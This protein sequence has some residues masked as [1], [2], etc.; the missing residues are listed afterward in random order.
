MNTTTKTLAA[1][2][3]LALLPASAYAAPVSIAIGEAGFE[4]APTRGAVT[5]APWKR[6]SNGS[7]TV[8]VES[9]ASLG[10]QVDPVPGGGN[11]LHYNN[12]S[13][14][15][16]YQVLA[17]TLEANTT[18]VLAI[19]AVDRSNLN[20]QSS[21][22]RFGTVSGVDD[23]TSG[24]L[25]ANDFFGE[26][27]LTPTAVVNTTPLNAPVPSTSDGTTNP[28]DGW[29][30]WSYTFTTGDSPAGLDDALRIEIIGTG[31]QSLFDNV[32]LTK[33]PVPEPGS[34]ALLGLGGLLIARRRRG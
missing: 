22:L 4:G 5:L 3:A 1:L 19:Q 14:E 34:L 8:G 11:Y 7:N 13:A 32:T 26:N 29:V 31:V 24:D 16:I 18:Y 23:G 33:E 12:G 21:E 15:S 17:E 6:G 9:Y 2:S 25:I 28:T 10:T 27:L 20:F 30:N